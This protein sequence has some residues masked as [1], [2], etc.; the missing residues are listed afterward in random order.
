MGTE[1]SVTVNFI[2]KHTLKKTKQFL[3]R[4]SKKAK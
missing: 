2:P 3:N 1:S 4:G